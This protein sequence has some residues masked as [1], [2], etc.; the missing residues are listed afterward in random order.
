M[1]ATYGAEKEI[2]MV[3]PKF[4]RPVFMQDKSEACLLSV[5]G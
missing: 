3:F 4:Q 2:K 5:S 1:V